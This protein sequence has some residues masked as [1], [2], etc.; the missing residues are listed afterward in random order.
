MKT[1]EFPYTGS[2]GPGDGWAGAVTVDL[3]DEQAERLEASMENEEFE[4]FEDDDSL[5]D[6]KKEVWEAMIADTVSNYC[7]SDP[8]YLREC[9]RKGDSL[10][11]CAKKLLKSNLATVHYP[12]TEWW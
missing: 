9:G 6:I 2:G 1:Y 4:D 12:G 3:T 7:L 8:D 5:E 10:E 11:V